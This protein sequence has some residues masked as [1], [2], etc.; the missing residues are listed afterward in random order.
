MSGWC[1]GAIDFKTRWVRAD[2]TPAHVGGHDHTPLTVFATD[3]VRPGREVERCDIAELNVSGAWHAV[4]LFSGR[5]TDWNALERVAVATRPVGQAHRDV[6]APCALEHQAGLAPTHRNRQR[7]LHVGHVQT[8][9]RRLVALDVQG[10]ASAGRW[11]APLS[12]FFVSR[13]DAD[14]FGCR[15]RMCIKSSLAHPYI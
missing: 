9:A 2:V 4:H 8:Q 5:Q 15:T 14:Q 7:L 11:A 12:R 10:S 1:S 6:E 3:L 13:C